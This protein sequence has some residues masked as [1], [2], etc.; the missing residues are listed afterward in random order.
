[1]AQAHDRLQFMKL[2]SFFDP[3]ETQ[4]GI[5][6]ETKLSISDGT[7]WSGVFPVMDMLLSNTAFVNSDRQIPS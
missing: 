3:A 1:M 5:A 6:G 2:D 4:F 7:R